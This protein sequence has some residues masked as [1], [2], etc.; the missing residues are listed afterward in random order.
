M[1]VI[2]AVIPSLQGGAD[3]FNG[4]LPQMAVESQ[5]P[6]TVVRCSRSA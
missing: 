4:L 2:T 5:M 6:K 1:M 3:A